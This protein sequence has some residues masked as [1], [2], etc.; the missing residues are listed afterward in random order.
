MLDDL[1][2]QIISFLQYDGRMP[3]TTIAAELGTT[4][5]TVRRRVKQLS[6][7]G[8]MQVVAIVEPQNMGWEEA[9]MI[10][11]SVKANLISTIA[12]EIAKLP[13]VAYLFQAAG[14]YDLIAEVFC[15]D[16]D[17]FVSFLNDKL[18]QIKGIDRTQSFMILKMH[19]LSYRWGEAHPPE[20]AQQQV[21]SGAGDKDS[22]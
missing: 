16:R 6:E 21:N 18:Q 13:E 22:P 2:R 1:D 5:G 12:D 9:A 20:Y 15:R 7:N 19:K 3:F 4:E 14:D 8:T 17:H 11:I 10:G